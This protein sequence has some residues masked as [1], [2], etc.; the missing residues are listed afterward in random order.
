VRRLI[1]KILL[2]TAGVLAFLAVLTLLG[3]FMIAEANEQAD[4]EAYQESVVGHGP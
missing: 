3:A 4:G 2:R 1:G